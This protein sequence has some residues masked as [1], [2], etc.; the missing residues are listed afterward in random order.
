MNCRYVASGVAVVMALAGVIGCTGQKAQAPSQ[1]SAN[2][3]AP[4]TPWGEPDL[5]GIWNSSVITPN[6]RP[7]QYADREFLTEA[8]VADIEKKAVRT[9]LGTGR[10]VRAL[11]GTPE[12]VEGAYNNVFTGNGSAGT[13]YDRSR[14]TSL[15]IDPKDGKM[16]Q[17]TEEGKKL[18]ASSTETRFG[19]AGENGDVKAAPILDVSGKPVTLSYA[20]AGGKGKDKNGNLLPG[21]DLEGRRNDNPEDRNDIE[22]CRG[23]TST[24]SGG[25]A[26]N[27]SRIVQGPGNITWYQEQGHGGGGY[28]VIPTDN[29]PHLPETI[30][31]WQGDSVGH[32]EGDTLVIDTTNFREQN[33]RNGV[34]NEK[35]HLIEKLTRLNPTDLRYEVTTIKPNMYVS[36]FTTQRTLML[37]DGVKNQIYESYCYEGNYALTTMLNGARSE[38]RAAGKGRQKTN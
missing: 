28:R 18:L 10:D 37:E 3:T 36:P 2:S 14:R 7:K 27:F 4:R 34:G 30:R 5:Q 9:T 16:P 6:E 25:V 24:G 21:V 13:H 22:R 29:R 1:A 15:I 31:F 26:A 8:E 17:L 11:K 35:L 12:D 38:E 19:V 33:T 20:R 32:W 23:L